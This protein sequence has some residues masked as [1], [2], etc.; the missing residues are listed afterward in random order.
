MIYTGIA[1]ETLSFLLLLY[2]FKW[3]ISIIKVC[4]AMMHVR[5]VLAMF[6]VDDIFQDGKT[7]K[8]K[9]METIIMMGLFL[10]NL[11]MILHCYTAKKGLIF[12]AISFIFFIWGFNRRIYGNK[13]NFSPVIRISLVTLFFMYLHIKLSNLHLDVLIDN[14]KS[15][16]ELRGIEKVKK[17]TE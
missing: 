16:S 15:I 5:I 6:Q 1:I 8:L 2:S 7:P 9:M 12:L 4:I 17:E 13:N 11:I 14:S 3:K 10:L